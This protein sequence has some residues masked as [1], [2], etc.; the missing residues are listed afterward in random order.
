MKFYILERKLVV[1]ATRI[2]KR[3]ATTATIPRAAASANSFTFLSRWAGVD[4]SVTAE[5]VR[6]FCSQGRDEE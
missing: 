1:D 2:E 6:F 4:G 5:A 3:P